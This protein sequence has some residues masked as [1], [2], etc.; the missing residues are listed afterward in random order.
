MKM[1][2]RSDLHQEGPQDMAQP[3]GTETAEQQKKPDQIRTDPQHTQSSPYFAG[4][5]YM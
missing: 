1:G 4:D 5:V 2:C 3:G